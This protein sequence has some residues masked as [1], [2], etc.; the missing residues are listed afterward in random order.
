MQAPA[1]AV[2]SWGQLIINNTFFAIPCK[3]EFA[4]IMPASQINANLTSAAETAPNQNPLFFNFTKTKINNALPAI[5][6]K[7]IG[8]SP[9]GKSPVY[10]EI[11]LGTKHNKKAASTPITLAEIKSKAFT[12]D[13][14]ISWLPKYGAITAIATNPQNCKVFTKTNFISIDTTFSCPILLYDILTFSRI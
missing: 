11:K 13:P 7:I 3:M 8:A 2:A 5:I 6:N 1:I 14:V 10:K 9:N 4:K 12:I